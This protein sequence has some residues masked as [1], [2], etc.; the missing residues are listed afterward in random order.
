MTEIKQGFRSAVASMYSVLEVSEVWQDFLEKQEA[1]GA[2]PTKKLNDLMEGLPDPVAQIALTLLAPTLKQTDPVSFEKHALAVWFTLS[3]VKA[4]VDEGV[5][6]LDPAAPKAHVFGTEDQ[7]FEAYKDH[8]GTPV[9]RRIV[10]EDIFTIYREGKPFIYKAKYQPA[11]HFGSVTTFDESKPRD[12]RNAHHD[13]NLLLKYQAAIEHNL[14]SGACI[15]VRGLVDLDFMEWACGTNAF[16]RG[17]VPDVQIIYNMML[18]SGAEYRFTLKKAADRSKE[19]SVENPRHSYTPEDLEV[20]SGIEH[21]L[22][23]PSQ[24]EIYEIVSATNIITPSAP[25]KTYFTSLGKTTYDDIKDPTLYREFSTLKRSGIWNRAK[26]IKPE[27]Y[28]QNTN[29]VFAEDNLNLENEPERLEAMIEEY[30]EVLRQNP[31]LAKMKSNYIL[32]LK[33]TPQYDTLKKQAVS[34]FAKNLGLVRAREME[35]RSDPDFAMFTEERA[36]LDWD[37][38]AEGYGLSVEHIM[39]D[40]IVD[41][42]SGQSGKIG[43]SYENSYDRFMTID[44][45]MAH[46]ERERDREVYQIKLHDPLKNGPKA[47]KTLIF[48]DETAQK[49]RQLEATMRKTNI[50]RALEYLEGT[51]LS[52]RKK[53]PRQMQHMWR[54]KEPT[55]KKYKQELAEIR[56]Q[57]KDMGKQIADARR[58]AYESAPPEKR[59]GV[60]TSDKVERLIAEQSAIGQSMVEAETRLW[61]TLK[62]LFDEGQTRSMFVSVFARKENIMKFIYVVRPDNTLLFAEESRQTQLG[63]PSHSE[64]NSGMNSY[65]AGEQIFIR[66]AASTGWVLKETNNGSGHYIPP[67][68]SLGFVAGCFTKELYAHFT[69]KGHD[70]EQAKALVENFMVKS[71]LTD[72]IAR[73]R[74]LRDAE[75]K[76]KL[77]ADKQKRFTERNNAN[78]DLG[79]PAGQLKITRPTSY[80]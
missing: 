72:A 39:L 33:D 65:G 78:P 75:F 80:L 3:R 27:R 21:A 7:V 15:E 16:N 42:V 63:R 47:K 5:E 20:V 23:N 61:E 34:T 14:I 44:Q 36:S 9:N 13:R 1:F 77:P 67:A 18:P 28:N 76:F 40:S 10:I 32:G 73:G 74:Q 68:D 26:A 31:R 37:G 2:E 56:E 52:K 66:G 55:V 4:L 62:P 6:T 46:L 29:T 24:R 30:Q 8:D 38:P 58:E 11:R 49:V 25:L 22:K 51:D 69:Q 71:R 64:V 60:I 70:D 48:K 59:A 45:V 41:V 17:A 54:E 53:K 19:L 57:A 50:N 79:K 35:R 43:R 12:E